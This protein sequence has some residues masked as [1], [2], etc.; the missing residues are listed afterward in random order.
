M[1]RDGILAFLTLLFLS[2]VPAVYGQNSSSELPDDVVPSDFVNPWRE[3][4]PNRLDDIRENDYYIIAMVRTDYAGQTYTDTPKAMGDISNSTMRGESISVTADGNL[5]QIPS[6][7]E[8][9]MIIFLEE[10]DK[11]IQENPQAYLRAVYPRKGYITTGYSEGDIMLVESKAEAKKIMMRKTSRCITIDFNFGGSTAE[12]LMYRGSTNCFEINSGSGNRINLFSNKPV[13]KPKTDVELRFEQTELTIK[14]GETAP[15]PSISL[16][17]NGNR[18]D[19][20][21]ALTY[22]G[23]D[24]SAISINDDIIRAL[25]GGVRTTVT[26]R[27]GGNK[28]YNPAEATFNVTTQAVMPELQWSVSEYSVPIGAANDVPVI[29]N[30]QSL[31]LT[32]TCEGDAV[33]VDTSG[34][35]TIVKVGM[36]RVS[37]IFAGD[38]NYMARTAVVD[39]TVKEWEKVSTPWFDGFS[40]GENPIGT[41]VAIHCDTPGAQIRYTIARDATAP[42]PSEQ[43]SLYMDI[44][45]ALSSA[46]HWNI[47]A[48]SYKEGYTDSDVANL[49]LTITKGTYQLAFSQTDV[50]SHPGDTFNS[51]ALTGLPAD[52]N[53]TK[54]YASGNENVAKVDAQT[55]IVSVVGIGNVSISVTIGETEKYQSAEA[56]FTVRSLAVAESVDDLMAIGEDITTDVKIKFPITVTYVAPGNKELFG[57][58]GDRYLRLYLGSGEFPYGQGDIV[59]G[60]WDGIYT[61]VDGISREIEVRDCSLLQGS[62]AKDSNWSEAEI[63]ASTPDASY[64]NR[65]VLAKNIN[66][67][68]GFTPGSVVNTAN[69]R[70]YDRFGVVVSESGRYDIHG[71]CVYDNSAGSISLAPTEFA[72]RRK[73]LANLGFDNA[74]AEYDLSGD[75]MFTLP[76]AHGDTD[77]EIRYKVEYGDALVQDAEGR[78]FPVAEGIVTVRAICD[79]TYKFEAGEA[80][81]QLRIID[82]GEAGLCFDAVSLPPSDP[83]TGFVVGNDAKVS[84]ELSQGGSAENSPAYYPQ[85]KAFRM[86][87][88]NVMRIHVPG[89]DGIEKIVIF[90]NSHEHDLGI[91]SYSDKGL[92]TGNVW[93]ASEADEI[94]DVSITNGATEGFTLV[95]ALKVITSSSARK[96]D[97]DFSETYLRG[98]VGQTI[99]LPILKDNKGIPVEADRIEIRPEGILQLQPDGRSLLCLKEGEAEVEAFL[100]ADTEHDGVSAALTVGVK[101]NSSMAWHRE[102]VDVSPIYACDGEE[103]SLPVLYN[104]E[105]LSCAFNVS[106]EASVTV[107][108][109][110]MLAL[111]GK[112]GLSIVSAVSDETPLYWPAERS[113]ILDVTPMSVA[114][115]DFVNDSYGLPRGCSVSGE[116]VYLKNVKAVMHGDVA[117]SQQGGMSLEAG[118]TLR[119]EIPEGR[120]LSR[121][122]FVGENGISPKATVTEGEMA[123]SIWWPASSADKGYVDFVFTS[124]IVLDRLMV[125]YGRK[126]EFTESPGLDFVNRSIEGLPGEPLGISLTAQ[127]ADVSKAVIKVYR[128]GQSSGCALA[129]DRNGNG[130]FVAEEPGVYDLL[131]ALE[132]EDN[133][134][135]GLSVARAVVKRNVNIRYASSDVT[136]YRDEESGSDEIPRLILPD[137]VGTSDLIFVSTDKSVAT[138]DANGVVTICGDGETLIKATL[139]SEIYSTAE[140]C[141]RL[142]VYPRRLTPSDKDVYT[143]RLCMSDGMEVG[144]VIKIGEER[145]VELSVKDIPEGAAVWYRMFEGGASETELSKEGLEGYERYSASDGIYLYSG[146]N[147]DLAIRTLRGELVSSAR[148]WRYV[149]DGTGVAEAYASETESTFYTVDGLRLGH[150]VPT[151]PGIYIRVAGSH[152]DRVVISGR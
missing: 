107:D 69:L 43:S 36:A 74:E 18:V 92:L 95:K 70:I 112:P 76:K 104:P 55:G 56:S 121:V 114:G 17:E 143:L 126:G 80:M 90:T 7:P 75:E 86:Y 125:F 72:N 65:P 64:V 1:K 81:C 85:E 122:E 32:F 91:D 93:K 23:Y 21:P 144:D 3:V 98:T 148:V 68:D 28:S 38:D 13:V 123:Q 57:K 82:N 26:A 63:A 53:F 47:K 29:Q 46:G 101:R 44:P 145:G 22:S 73:M 15:I 54:R 89:N 34:R 16:Y 58:S 87:E 141:Y 151:S 77:A 8:G 97:I 118:S 88:G 110:G 14:Y 111:T 49:I 78:Y 84:V 5:S 115:F 149:T 12:N 109:N 127:G 2:V 50:E 113:F 39:I 147:G 139:S 60:G 52:D 59:P 108:S 120:K 35:I 103:T 105:N 150:E 132:A 42:E 99:E 4:N 19:M 117:L 67:P 11:S 102:G 124:G 130:Y 62:M 133:R 131:A 134:A 79:A 30:P 27:F 24:Q 41:G 37:A 129:V 142:R 96:I 136:V 48:R 20:T 61:Y 106:D 138:V 146:R 9:T 94:S 128:D 100:N 33:S 137:G 40:A 135:F 119:I 140:A 71:V 51:P 25:K 10:L 116:S 31:P 83:L 6:I 66:L 45:V 152:R